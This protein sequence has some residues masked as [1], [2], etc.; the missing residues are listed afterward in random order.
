MAAAAVPLAALVPAA[1]VADDPVQ[2]PANHPLVIATALVIDWQPVAGGVGVAPQVTVPKHILLHVFGT[3]STSRR[4]EERT[5][6]LAPAR[7]PR[8]TS[9]TTVAVA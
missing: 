3:T 5:A 6:S 1:P 9:A 8:I 2:A 7:V 4:E